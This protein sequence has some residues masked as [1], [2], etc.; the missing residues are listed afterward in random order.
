MWNSYIVATTDDA[1]YY[2]DQHALA[3]RIS[4]EK[5]KRELKEQ[6][7]A[8]ASDSLLHPLSIDI[9]ANILIEQKIEDLT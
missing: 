2:I 8:A 1:L 3:E 9:P 5:M 4:F 7:N 6:T